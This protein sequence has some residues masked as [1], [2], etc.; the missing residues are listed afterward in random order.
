MALVV[1]SSGTHGGCDGGDDL[2]VAPRVHGAIA[3]HP[4]ERLDT[5][6]EVGVGALLLGPL[7]RGEDHVG[8]LR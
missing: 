6:L 2:E 3:H 8:A 5:A 4:A 7:R 1:E